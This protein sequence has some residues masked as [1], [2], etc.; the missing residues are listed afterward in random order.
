[1]PL[2]DDFC[3]T[4]ADISKQ[5]KDK[6]TRKFNPD[7]G[8]KL[9]YD[10]PFSSL[11]PIYFWILD[12]L[13][14]GG[15]GAEKKKLVDNFVASPG[16]GQFGEMGIRMSK[17]QEEGMKI[18]GTVNTIIKSIINLIYD[19]KEFEARL[20][21]YEDAKSKDKL[22]AESGMLA[23]KQIWMDQVD[24][25]RGRGSIN[26]MTYELGFRTLRDAFMA[27]KSLEDIEKMDLLENVKRVLK[28]RFSEFLEWVKLSEAELKKR[29]DIEEIYLRSQLDSLRLYSRWARPY[30]KAAEELAQRGTGVSEGSPDIVSVF[31]TTVLDLVL[32]GIGKAINP[33]SEFFEEHGIPEK[34]MTHKFE[35]KYYP[36]ILIEFWFRGIPSRT[37]KGDYSLG[38]KV[39]VYFR[40]FTMNDDE[41]LL[42]NYKN[43]KSELKE[44]LKLV[45]GMTEET[46]E[47]LKED[48]EHFLEGQNKEKKKEE[49]KEKDEQ[50]NPFSA[51]A[52]IFIKEKKEEKKLSPEEQKKEKEKKEEEKA[53]KLEKEGI[54]DDDYYEQFL[55]RI[56]KKKAREGGFKLFE[57]YKKTHNMASFPETPEFERQE[58]MAGKVIY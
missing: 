26:S 6:E 5:Y 34:L 52:S 53:K 15:F 11:E 20:K 4:I 32:L 47:T 19:L 17:M 22:V 33:E 43:K 37:P 10:N 12:N 57:T 49:E 24:M 39:E 18:L 58:I 55:R 41:L 23:L 31:G 9:G 42:F 44:A 38:G 3:K 2:I 7:W 29:K 54:R 48:I 50:L 35:R 51:L 46:I 45:S 8:A 25:K 13:G 1:M 27:A 56:A 36:C 30:L 21:F 40:T 16:S 14:V 28:P